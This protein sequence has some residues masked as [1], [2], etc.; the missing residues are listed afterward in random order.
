MPFKTAIIIDLPDTKYKD[1]ADLIHDAIRGLLNDL[2]ATEVYDG[3]DDLKY[4][5]TALIGRWEQDFEDQC[6][7]CQR[8]IRYCA[9]YKRSCRRC[10][11]HQLDIGGI[12]LTGGVLCRMI[13]PTKP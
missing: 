2:W 8:E 12:T 5:V 9:C 7:T 10:H 11:G 6:R 1:K 4:D 3:P 13:K